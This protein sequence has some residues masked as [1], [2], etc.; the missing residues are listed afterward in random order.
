MHDLGTTGGVAK[1]LPIQILAAESERRAC[2]AY[3]KT[4]CGV[5][6]CTTMAERPLGIH[7]DDKRA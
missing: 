4:M 5:T 6:Y 2:L 3:H 7:K 1:L